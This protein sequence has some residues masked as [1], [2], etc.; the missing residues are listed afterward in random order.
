MCTVILIFWQDLG[1]TGGYSVVA[2]IC[3]ETHKVDFFKLDIITILAR[4]LFIVGT[5]LCIISM[6]SNIPGCYSADVG[7]HSSAI[8]M[9]FTKCPLGD[10][11]ENHWYKFLRNAL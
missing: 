10:K 11:I 9:A 5:D 4:Y 8:V 3:K 1:A 6:M 7:S 2:V